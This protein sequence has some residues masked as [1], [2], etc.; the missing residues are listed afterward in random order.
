MTNDGAGGKRPPF[1]GV[2]GMAAVCGRVRAEMGEVFTHL[3]GRNFFQERF[4]ADEFCNPFLKEDQVLVIP[5][6]RAMRQ[7]FGFIA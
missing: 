5:F 4:M 6:D 7:A 3:F 1:D 2:E